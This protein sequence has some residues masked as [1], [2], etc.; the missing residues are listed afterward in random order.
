[1]KLQK[2]LL[3]L[4]LLTAL[5]TWGRP[6]ALENTGDDNLYQP[7]KCQLT[8]EDQI[9]L[10]A[11]ECAHHGRDLTKPEADA[12]VRQCL[13]A[14]LKRKSSSPNIDVQKAFSKRDRII[15]GL[16]AMNVT[17]AQLLEIF[18]NSPRVQE[19]QIHTLTEYGMKVNETRSLNDTL[20]PKIYNETGLN[21]FRGMEHW[22]Y[23]HLL[24]HRPSTY[25]E[26]KYSVGPNPAAPGATIVRATRYE[27]WSNERP[28]D[29]T[30][31]EEKQYSI[32]ADE[33]RDAYFPDD[34]LWQPG[35][36]SASR[37]TLAIGKS[38][39][40]NQLH[41]QLEKCI[42]K[43]S[44]NRQRPLKFVSQALS[45][46][47]QNSQSVMVFSGLDQETAA[48]KRLSDRTGSQLMSKES[49]D[50]DVDFEEMYADWVYSSG[51]QWR[52]QWLTFTF[53]YEFDT[54]RLNK[55]FPNQLERRQALQDF[56][57]AENG[58]RETAPIDGDI[59]AAGHR[60]NRERDA[61][62]KRLVQSGR[63]VRLYS[64]LKSLSRVGI[65]ANPQKAGL[66]ELRSLPIPSELNCSFTVAGAVLF[67]AYSV[68]Q[69]ASSTAQT[70]FYVGEVNRLL[71][72]LPKNVC[73]K[74]V[75]QV[76]N[77][78]QVVLKQNSS[79]QEAMKKNDLLKY[80]NLL[81]H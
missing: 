4:S 20:M 57:T 54:A 28:A 69:K 72:Q 8:L 78:M 34:L 76:Q 12:N 18:K 40:E 9:P 80:R 67:A 21:A 22:G 16:L 73:E 24:V 81:I 53:A 63:I 43:Q 79:L 66:I 31:F 26:L 51:I 6:A 19:C 48:A 65:G 35:E 30:P 17:A 33:V 71:K 38:D 49:A 15:N 25:F 46:A 7:L 74:E 55:A 64:A 42:P 27:K 68:P 75:R 44:L 77:V 36:Q 29:L 2:T 47:C 62:L 14:R 1:M 10:D 37:G 60:Q 50:L 59:S 13:E 41:S 32:Y 3:A 39:Y 5:N 61:A 70:K 23:E 58:S 56:F 52:P 11:L 45:S